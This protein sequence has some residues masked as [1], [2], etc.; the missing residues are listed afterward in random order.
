MLS[1]YCDHCNN[2][3]GDPQEPP[4]R[5]DCLQTLQIY[6]CYH[7]ENYTGSFSLTNRE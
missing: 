1:V 5:G 2:K 7:C 4:Y 6:Y 3:V